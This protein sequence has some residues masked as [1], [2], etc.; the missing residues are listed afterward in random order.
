MA[1]NSLFYR[2]IPHAVYQVLF[3]FMLRMHEHIVEHALSSVCFF[4]S[5]FK[6]VHKRSRWRA[7]ES[8]SRVNSEKLVFA[9]DAQRRFAYSQKFPASIS[10]ARSREALDGTQQQ[11]IRRK[12]KC[13]DLQL[14]P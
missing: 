2:P 1:K 4:T 11:T 5:L 9:S 6:S 10:C 7:M 3:Q 8:K 14:Q 12:G 13:R